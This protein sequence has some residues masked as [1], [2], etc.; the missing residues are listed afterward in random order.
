MPLPSYLDVAEVLG[1]RIALEQVGVEADD[2]DGHVQLVDQGKH[3]G[4]ADLG[5]RQLAQLLLVLIQGPVEL[6]QAA[7]AELFAGCPASGVERM[8]SRRHRGLRVDGHGVRGVAD[9]LAGGGIERGER[10]PLRHELPVDQQVPADGRRPGT[11]IVGI[12]PSTGPG[13]RVALTCHAASCYVLLLRGKLY[14]HNMQI[15]HPSKRMS[16]L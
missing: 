7:D 6:V 2:L 4:R 8:A 14:S 9:H 1:H 15:S 11:G 16:V 13:R 10:P 12:L 5:D 3:A